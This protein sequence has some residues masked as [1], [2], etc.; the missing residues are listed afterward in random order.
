MRRTALASAFAATA[1]LALQVQ[2]AAPTL[3]SVFPPGGRQGQTVDL[4]L[5]GKFDPWPCELWFSVPGFSFE[6]DPEKAG[7]GK[8][9][10]PAEAPEGP[11]LVRAHNAEGASASFIFIVGDKAEIVDE[12]KDGNTIAGAAPVERDALPIVVN[13]TLSAASELDAWRLSLKKG[14]TLHSLVEAYGLRSPLDPALHLHDASGNRVLV[15]HD[16]PANLDAGFS[17]EVP[18][19]GDYVVSLVGFAHP[20][21]ANV[22]YVGSKNS[23]Y[24]LHL[25][26]SE[27]DLP[28]RLLPASLGPDSPDPELASGGNL[29]GTLGKPAQPNRHT[30]KVKKGEKLIVRVEGRELRFPID[31]VLRILKPDGGEIRREDDT[32][33]SKDP[34]YLWTVAEDGVHT[35][36]VSD[37]FGRGGPDMRYRLSASVPRPDFTLVADKEIHAMERGKPLEIKLKLTRLHGHTGELDLSVSGLPESFVAT[38]TGK[39]PDKDGELVLKIE[40]KDDAPGFSGPF[41]IVAREQ[42]GKADQPGNKDE[43]NE[44][45]ES[46]GDRDEPLRREAVVSF[47]DDNWRGPY[48][49]DE[50]PDLWLSL[51]A[52][53]VEEKGEQNEKE[54]QE[55]K[56]GP[57]EGKK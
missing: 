3:E 17:F 36:E 16:L 41:R 2:A 38:P 57:G 26:L 46:P 12:E 27:N 43:G 31:P 24:R 34:Q 25:A 37:R 49:I 23:H 40:A 4:T 21:A 13:G 1:A 32:G 20:P 15:A 10:I 55:K 35:L 54:E 45:G 39:T 56:A 30:I 22:A 5:S 53:P 33:K 28:S 52:P 7:S 29:V 48:A 42:P 50:S 6:P 47:A 11:V 14:D 44:N 9:S 19:A 51:P 8:L 18:R